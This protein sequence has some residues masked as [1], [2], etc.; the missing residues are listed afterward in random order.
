MSLPI[1]YALPVA[2]KARYVTNL[3]DTPTLGILPR[4]QGYTYRQVASY[5]GLSQD[6]DLRQELDLTD[7]LFRLPICMLSMSISTFYAL[8]K[9]RTPP[10]MGYGRKNILRDTEYSRQLVY[11]RGCEHQYMLDSS[12]ISADVQ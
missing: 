4:K 1:V 12:E 7:R 5:L 11:W 3:L 10:K 2:T 6:C 8:T 9:I